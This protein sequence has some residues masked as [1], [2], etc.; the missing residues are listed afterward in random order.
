M[1]TQLSNG[2]RISVR[3][4][5]EAGYS[6]PSSNQYVFSY[7][8]R[9]ENFRNETVQLLRRHWIITNATGGVREV[10]GEGVIGQQPILE[11]G[12]V[13]IYDSWCPLPS[14][15]GTMHGS[16]KMRILDS[17]TYFQAE[18][19]RFRMESSVMLNWPL[20]KLLDQYKGGEFLR[21]GRW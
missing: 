11:P 19:P 18:V 17:D 12:D 3:S 20:L 2:I 9:I 13:H 16:Y 14:P 6:R 4:R 21:A 15:I 7:R 10:E 1:P 8:V 5:Y